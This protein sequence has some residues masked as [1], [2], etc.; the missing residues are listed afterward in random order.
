MD[1]KPHRTIAFC[2]LHYG[3]PYLAAAI[4][5]V[6]PQVDHIV[7]L[8][9]AHPSQG[10]T[11]SL[12]CPDTEDELRV[13]AAPFMDKITW[14]YGNWANET[15]HIHAVRNY[16]G[17]YDWVWRFDADEITPPGM[18]AEMIRQAKTS[19]HAEYRVPFVHF[20]RSFNKVCRDGQMPIRLY[21]VLGGKGLRYLD[22]RD[23]WYVLH[24]GYAMPTRYIE[25]KLQCSGHRPEFRKDWFE[26]KWLAN[27]HEDVH[28]VMHPGHWNAVDYDKSNM[29]KFLKEHK[30]FHAGVVE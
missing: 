23:T 16:V 22:S 28:P 25:Y 1:I 30:Y 29:P 3:R 6:Y 2:I 12:P 20:W 21:R 8:Y 17:S 5:S 14:V 10:F 9:T 19:D 4:E 11:P 26:T 27:C 18:V 13:E 15:E 24:F 7:I